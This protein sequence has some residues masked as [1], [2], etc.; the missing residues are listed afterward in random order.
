MKKIYFIRA[1]TSKT[2]GAEVYLSRLVNALLEKGIKCEVLHSRAPK[3]LPSW[4]RVVLFNCSVCRKKGDRFY[5]SL[6]RIS[7]PD[8]YRAG[9]GVHKVFLRG[10]GK[11]K[12]NPLHKVY[13]YLERRCFANAKKIIANSKMIKSQ[14]INEYEVE[15]EKIDVIYNGVNVS[16]INQDIAY[17]AMSGEF[18]IC[19]KDKIIL[20]VGSGF[21]RKGVEPFLYMLAELGD[22]DFKAFVVGKE[23]NIKHYIKIAD[24][25][26]VL[27]KVIFT[28]PRLDVGYFYTVSDIFILPTSYEPF[29]NVILEAMSY[30]TVVFT[31]RQNG[32]S[33]I[34]KDEFIMD[35]PNDKSVL[36]NIIKLL[37][38]DNELGKVK[39]DNLKL[40]SKF[41]M[42]ENVRQTLNVLNGLWK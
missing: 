12:L 38:D 23:K 16:E 37:S 27:N 17:K 20:Y 30:K 1:N 34:L 33:E 24:K 6:E 3:Y 4:L 36:K 7:C 21:K 40:A 39:A 42:E 2:G 26:G 22:L 41:S 8:V 18:G 28:G 29:S 15:P 14:I 19:K 10:A 35:H 25:L 5:F 32:A 31:T 11:S 13:L 9:D